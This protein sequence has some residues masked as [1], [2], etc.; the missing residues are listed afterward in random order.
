MSNEKWQFSFFLKNMLFVIY[1][2]FM[3]YG[4]FFAEGF[5]R[6]IERDSYNLVPFTEIRRYI[7]AVDQ[8]GAGRVFV[9][10]I[11]NLVLFLPFG[12]LLPLLWPKGDRHHP[13]IMIAT[14][15][16]FSVF[17][18]AMQFVTKSGVCDIDDVILNTIGGML[19]YLL[20][21]AMDWAAEWITAKQE[22][23]TVAD[24][25]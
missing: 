13:F 1:I 8:I 5:G 25:E 2:I 20:Y 10:L 14:I 12:Y 23:D 4:L 17:V 9:N 7:S 19:G 11:G 24:D 15:V 3:C 22:N 18:E 6:S 21:R 16:I